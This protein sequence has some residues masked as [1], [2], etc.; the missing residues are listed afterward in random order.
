MK[1]RSSRQSEQQRFVARFHGYQDLK[2]AASG[3]RAGKEEN[4]FF[5][6]GPLAAKK[7]LSHLE[8][9]TMDVQKK[10]VIASRLDQEMQA[11][12]ATRWSPRQKVALACRILASE[13]H[14]RG[15]AG[16]ITCRADEPSNMLTLG[17]GVGFDEACASSLA[18]VDQDLYP[19][20]GS[21]MANPGVRF[22]S[23]IYAR[24][25]DVNAIVHTHPPACAA[26]SMI[27]EPLEVAHMDATPLFDDCAFLAEWPGLPIGD[28]EGRIISEAMGSKHAIL[29]ANHGLLTAGK[30]IEEATMLAVWMEHAAEMQLR[31]RAVGAI[32]RIAPD[33]A[34]ES[35]DFL[36]K[37]K[38][39]GLTFAYFARRELRADASTIL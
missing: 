3:V 22:H 25:A 2:Q 36:R 12:T 38:V 31:A 20:E 13:G 26:L 6:G 39:L 34:V 18:L 8:R 14:W 7:S 30:T 21:R 37:P 28:E 24:R 11:L 4:P 19:L 27:G 35:R 32:K 17:F 9:N 16:Q 10:D 1:F 33:L 5:T 15:L 23:W 29:L